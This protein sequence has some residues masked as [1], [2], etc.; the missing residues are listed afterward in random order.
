ML[1]LCIVS[2]RRSLL[3]Y[4]FNVPYPANRTR[5]D[6]VQPAMLAAAPTPEIRTEVQGQL[7]W[8]ASVPTNAAALRKWMGSA[9]QWAAAN[10]NQRILIGEFGVYKL[11]TAAADRAVWL[12]DV[13]QIAESLDW[14]WCVWEANLGFGLFDGDSID[15]A[16]LRALIDQPV[17]KTFTP[18]PTPGTSPP[19]NPGPASCTLRLGWEELVALRLKGLGVHSGGLGAQA[20]DN[21]GVWLCVDASV[22]EC[23]PGSPVPASAAGIPCFLYNERLLRFEWWGWNGELSLV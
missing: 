7:D 8:L 23:G 16:S 10:P 6:A 2:E 3:P 4:F 1:S 22:A 14:G 20:S 15:M 11:R 18:T 12:R 17:P 13:R 21:Y 19:P 9:T 5:M